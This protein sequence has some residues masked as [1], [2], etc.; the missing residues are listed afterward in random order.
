MSGRY[1][2]LYYGFLLLCIHDHLGLVYGPLYTVCVCV[3]VCTYVYSYQA[4]NSS[5]TIKN[6]KYLQL[7]TIYILLLMVL[8][9]TGFIDPSEHFNSPLCTTPNAPR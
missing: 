2:L 4:N 7:C 3:A 6:G 8:I 9:A 5:M 1:S